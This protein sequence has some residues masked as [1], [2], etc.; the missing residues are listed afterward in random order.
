[1]E[2]VI[3]A[4]SSAAAKGALFGVALSEAVSREYT[5]NDSA[6]SSNTLVSEG[7]DSSVQLPNEN[8]PNTVN[9]MKL[10]VV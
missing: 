3:E 5:S 1:M 4:F 8:D 9:K 10:D 2:P 7:D 6:I